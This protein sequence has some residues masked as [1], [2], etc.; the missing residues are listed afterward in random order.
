MLMIRASLRGES[1]LFRVDGEYT[2]DRRVE[3][4]CLHARSGETCLNE[5]I[6]KVPAGAGG[7]VSGGA[8]AA[9]LTGERDPS[10]WAE[11]VAQLAELFARVGPEPDRVHGDD[12]I[13][14]G[15][16]MRQPVHRRMQQSD[17]LGTNRSRVARAGLAD[18]DLG[19]VDAVDP[20]PAGAAGQL[21]DGESWAE[22]DLEHP[23]RVLHVEQ[24]DH[25][26][27][28]LTVGAAVGHDPADHPSD[29]AVRS[30]ELAHDVVD[31]ALLERC[32]PHGRQ[33]TTSSALHVKMSEEAGEPA[34]VSEG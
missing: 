29:H 16:E 9:G 19:V 7:G 22:A 17:P 23:L 25:P 24:G 8:G 27:V 28:A 3:M 33:L 12:R 11:H 14:R 26:E 6:V 21:S 15:V 4:E 10:A 5:P 2:G 34:G 32:R 30:A 1:A 20:S 13:E 18:R 31:H